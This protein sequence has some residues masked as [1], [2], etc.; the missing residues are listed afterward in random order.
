[1]NL[2]TVEAVVQTGAMETPYIRGGHGKPLLLLKSCGLI[3]LIEDPLFAALAAEFR[4]IAVDCTATSTDWRLGELIEGLGL[5]RPRI[6]VEAG[7]HSMLVEIAAAGTDLVDRVV[8]LQPN[9]H[10]ADVIHLLRR[11]D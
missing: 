8:V 2:K 11:E 6:V 5:E 3:D 7:F 9:H 4:V 1:M 10:Y